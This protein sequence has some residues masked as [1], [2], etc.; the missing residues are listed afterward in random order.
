MADD[1]GPSGNGLRELA[2]GFRKRTLVT[3]RLAGKVGLAMAKRTLRGKDAEPGAPSSALDAE[4]AKDAARGL[5]REIG[6][7]KGL[8]MKVGQMA[9][10]LPG[11]L[12]PEAQKVLS[13]LQ[14]ESV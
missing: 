14:A 1:D 5:V 4:K 12:P 9:S 6:A 8:V 2:S 13:E 3:A 10:Y 11:A 7:L